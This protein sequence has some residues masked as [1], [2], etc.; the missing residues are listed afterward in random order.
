MAI[1]QENAL[2]MMDITQQAQMDKEQFDFFRNHI[3]SFVEWLVEGAIRDLVS[4]GVDF[5]LANSMINTI[6]HLSKM[7]GAN[8]LFDYG[9]VAQLMEGQD[10]A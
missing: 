7:A 10:N 3:A 5:D 9:V 1:T 2:R 6:S 8:D 4:V